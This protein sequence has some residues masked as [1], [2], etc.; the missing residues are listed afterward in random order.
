M[1]IEPFIA[2]PRP[3]LVRVVHG[4]FS[5]SAHEILLELALID[6]TPRG[7]SPKIV[8]VHLVN[9]TNQ[10][11]NDYGKFT[12]SDTNTMFLYQIYFVEDLQVRKCLS[13]T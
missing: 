9:F 4:N 5:W 7:V 13:N 12:I 10:Q 3:E 8:S 2:N 6:K 11:P 1:P